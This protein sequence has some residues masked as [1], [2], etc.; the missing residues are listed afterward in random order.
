LLFG[1]YFILG[2]LRLGAWVGTVASVAGGIAL[3]ILLAVLVRPGWATP[4]G[5]LAKKMFGPSPAIRDLA[6]ANRTQESADA[7]CIFA[8][9]TAAY[10]LASRDR[11]KDDQR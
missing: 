2:R 8:L 1:I 10:L 4:G 11:R 5:Y 7:A 3:S 6:S 9:L